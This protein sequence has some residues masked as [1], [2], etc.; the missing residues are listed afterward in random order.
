M[1][2]QRDD[3][4]NHKNEKE[5]TGNA[6]CGRNYSREPKDGGD[7]GYNQKNDHPRKHD[8]PLFNAFIPTSFY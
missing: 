8:D 5:N 1:R 3:K 7:Q 2:N 4:E 6:C